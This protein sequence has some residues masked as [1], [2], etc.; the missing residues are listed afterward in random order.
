MLTRYF[1]IYSSLR[2]YYHLIINI[3]PIAIFGLFIFL[4]LSVWSIFNGEQVHASAT[5]D[6]ES[7][8]VLEQIRRAQTINDTDIIFVGDSSCL[9][10]IDSQYLSTTLDVSVESLCNLGFV[11]P[12][13][14]AKL[15]ELYFNRGKKVRHVVIVLHPISWK[16]Q[17]EWEEWETFVSQYA[18]FSPKK[19]FSIKDIKNTSIK[20]TLTRLRL[21]VLGPLVYVPL[22][23]AYGNYF[24]SHEAFVRDIR[25]HNG[26]TIDPY[27][28]LEQ[29]TL[30]KAMAVNG[31]PM[32]DRSVVEQTWDYSADYDFKPTPLFFEDLRSVSPAIQRY[33]GT[34]FWL[35]ITPIPGNGLSDESACERA[36]VIEKIINIMGLPPNRVIDMPATMPDYLFSKEIHL[37][38]WGRYFFTNELSNHLSTW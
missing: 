18:N 5:K 34:T 17:P 3:A 21:E 11:G 24:G 6:I 26:N 20:E 14:Y 16:R 15:L 7:L 12:T 35:L 33:N 2:I 1:S 29:P 38:R 28:G 30:E 23:G 13:G 32:Y 4:M 36:D 8:I 19:N 31:W 10:G 37:N 27:T 25:L 9:M 22:P